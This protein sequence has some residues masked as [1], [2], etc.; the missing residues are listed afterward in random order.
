MRYGEGVIRVRCKQGDLAR[1][2]AAWNRL[3]EGAHVLVCRAHGEG[4]WIVR[5][6]DEPAFAL[7]EDRQRYIVTRT[8]VA[9]D[10]ALDPLRGAAAL[11]GKKESTG[12]IAQR[13][14]RHPEAFEA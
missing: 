11:E 13:P 10:W 5:L 14:H 3:L 4:N 7:S 12:S 8:L 2:K 9:P 1:I 6:Q